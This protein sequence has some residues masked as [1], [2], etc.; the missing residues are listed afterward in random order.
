MVQSDEGENFFQHYVAL[1]NGSNGV[2]FTYVIH[3]DFQEEGDA[4]FQAIV[5]SIVLGNGT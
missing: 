4:I 5:D 1:V 2:D 3:E